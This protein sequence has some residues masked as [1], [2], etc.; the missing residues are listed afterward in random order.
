LR[1]VL[2]GLEKSAP[3]MP[4]QKLT[5][6][7]KQEAESSDVAHLYMRHTGEPHDMVGPGEYDP[8]GDHIT[9][10]T[11][12]QTTFHTSRSQRNL[13][14]PSPA[15]DC[16][17]P[18]KDIPGPGSYEVGGVMG[19]QQPADSLAEAL[20]TYQFASQS[21]MAHQA[22]INSEK[23]SP[24]PGQYD[25]HGDMEKL[26]KSARERSMSGM[27]RARFGGMSARVGW[28]RSVYQPYKDPYNIHHVPGP[29][30]YPSS[31]SDF[32]VDPKKK[33]AEKVLP[34]ARKK[35]FYGVHHPTLIMALQEAQ[36]PLQAF[37]S[38]DD[39]ACNKEVEQSTPAPWQYKRE[40]ARSHSM[41]ADI[42]ERAKV[43]RKGVFGTCADRFYGSPLEGRAGLPDPGS[44]DDQGASSNAEPRFMFQSQSPRFHNPPGPREASATRVGHVE[45]PA[46][47][48]YVVEKEPSYRS[49]YRTPRQDHLSFGSCKQ[50]FEA[51]KDIFVGHT[52]NLLNPGPGEY[53]VPSA[54]HR[55]PGAAGFRDRRKPPVVGC[56]TESVGP[57]SYMDDIGTHMLRKTFNVSTHA[58]V[59]ATTPRRGLTGGPP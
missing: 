30:H 56:T 18:P 42:R 17:L 20:N 4:Q 2:Q 43:G 24:G 19:D 6:G 11:L 45:T 27:D 51:N 12:P 39:R 3:S 14:E 37:N 44:F 49:P 53:S 25:M 16:T 5:P 35:R 47:G 9:Q 40:E 34:S 36:G 46:P 33:E 22:S 32:P 15:I 21:P 38:T 7:Q 54:R 50:R 28:A 55:V 8:K 23:V 58:L 48:D 26:V 31:K 41:Q 1:P 59:D 57:G 52:P 29:G 13:W 10:R